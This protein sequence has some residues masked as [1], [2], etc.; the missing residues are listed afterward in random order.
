MNRF[1]VVSKNYKPG[2]TWN[3]SAFAENTLA[4]GKRVV[5]AGN[6]CNTR[7]IRA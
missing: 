3:K 4:S 7:H 5:D 1:N 2:F 6:Q